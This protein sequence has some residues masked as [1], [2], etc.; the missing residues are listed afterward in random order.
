MIKKS[1][2]KLKNN[3]FNYTKIEI[4]FNEIYLEEASFTI[5]QP[6]NQENN[7]GNLIS[8][9]TDEGKELQKLINVFDAVS[10]LLNDWYF[11]KLA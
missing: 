3:I 10:S 2:A 5:S 4:A 9:I 1:K 6:D 8:L 7:V 11:D